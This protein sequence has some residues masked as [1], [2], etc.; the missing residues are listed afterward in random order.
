M[1]RHRRQRS[2][3]LKVRPAVVEASCMLALRLRSAGALTLAAATVALPST[4]AHATSVVSG[5]VH[6]GRGW[7]VIALSP[8]GTSS[9][10]KAGRSGAFRVTLAG[11]GRGAT[12]QLVRPSGR[13]FGPVVLGPARHG[14]VPVALSG[15]TARLGQ[16]RLRTGYAV[17]SP[18]APRSAMASVAG[19]RV[20]RHGKPVGAGHLGLGGH[21]SRARGT[22]R[23]AAV[24]GGGTST[25]GAD[26]D[27]DGLPSALDADDNGNGTPDA[28]DPASSAA[29]GAGLFSEIQ[30]RL[31]NSLNA[32]AMTVTRAQI[33]TM[34]RDDLRLNFF[35]GNQVPGSGAAV[36]AIDVDCLALSYCRAGGG[37]AIVANGGNTPPALVGRTWST[38]DTNAD[39][40]PDLP[41]NPMQPNVFSLQ[42]QPNVTS[43]QIGPGDTYQFHL[44]TGSGDVIVPTALTTYFLT[45]PAVATLDAAPVDYP[46]TPATL[47][48]QTNPVRMTG[49]TLRMEL[50]RPQ[51]AALPGESGSLTDQ[52]H[53]H[54]GISLTNDAGH[55][56][57]A[58]GASAYSA[59]SPT[60][61]PR[62]GT[63]DRAA[64][65]FP[66]TDTGADAAPS[67]ANKM[68]FTFDLG[69][70]LRRN[71]V[72]PTA[73]LVAMPVMAVDEARPGGVDRA[74]QLIYVCFAGCTVPTAPGPGPG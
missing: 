60:L 42:I 9:A 64:D 68:A 13:Y 32:D 18:R 33:D 14:R 2:R 23:S 43:S 26:P 30:L 38:V 48:T 40:L 39:G 3:L 66:L 56:E 70:C 61:Q 52:G 16:L 57:I 20:D 58:C 31:E 73:K 71:G 24:G 7:T 19:A 5:T 72:D 21:P 46:V 10:A 62:A 17:T 22:V 54:Y 59:L 65:L 74:S 53:L 44:H 69:G 63:G 45:T 36:R 25:P 29:Q 49:D 15:R 47:G 12:L 50:W 27:H 35:L 34:V 55:Q 51:R 11:T 6:G 28:V 8:S 4:P 41:A 67:A 37:T 1:R